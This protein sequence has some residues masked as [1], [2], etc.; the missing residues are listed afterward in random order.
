MSRLRVEKIAL[1]R[2]HCSH[3]I[4]SAILGASMSKLPREV[5]LLGMVSLFNDIST[6]MIYPLLPLFTVAVL[7]ATA[8]DLGWIEGTAQGVVALM[9][10]WAGIASDRKTRVPW[11]R[12]GYGLPVA[13][14]LML[15]VAGSWPVVLIGRAVDRL[16]KGFRSSPRD[17]LIADVTPDELRGRAYGL[18]RALDTAGAFIGVL[19]AA[20]LLWWLPHRETRPIRIVIAVAAGLG[21]V[22]LGVSCF[23]REPAARPIA[24]K[25]ATPGER[26]ALPP[27]YWRTLAILLVF[28]LANSSDTFVLLRASDVGLAPWT[29]AIAY[30]VYNLVY[31]V[32]SYPAG[33][34]SDRFGRWGIVG[35]GWVI[36]AISYAAFAVATP[37]RIWPAFAVYGLFTAL[38]DGVGKA[39]IADHAPREHRGR[40]LG[41]F[42]LGTA[43][44]TLVSSVAAGVLWDRVGH[45][46]TFWA[47]AVAALVA[48]VVLVVL[49]P[50][51]KR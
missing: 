7:G 10:A 23:V 1:F 39:L 5:W 43:V 24:P 34:L 19:G 37:S 47:G 44:T 31:T 48:L 9:T 49:R 4:E 33:A 11:I 36:Y 20:A 45:A 30:A 46:A 40:A 2:L 35:A 17:A 6:E 16:G 51:T 42:Y 8:T 41:Y 12:F 27:A 3:C 15:A 14:K 28:A 25:H 26:S 29:V 18:D 38:T 13:G 21:L 50:R 32:A 22:A